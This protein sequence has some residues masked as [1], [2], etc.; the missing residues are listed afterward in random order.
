MIDDDD[1]EDGDEDETRRFA[2]S[3]RGGGW[4][5]CALAG[6]AIPTQGSPQSI[7]AS[8][9]PLSPVEPAPAHDH[10]DAAQPSSLVPVK[11][12]FLDADH[13]APARETAGA[14]RRPR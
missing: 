4:L 8:K 12:F 10:H 7:P 3:G 2:A 1:D 9:V 5:C 13:T 11:V 6:C 14:A